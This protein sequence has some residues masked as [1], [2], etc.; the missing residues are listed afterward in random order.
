MEISFYDAP[1]KINSKYISYVYS[2]YRGT[3]LD[4]VF[5]KV[6]TMH[7]LIKKPLYNKINNKKIKLI[8]S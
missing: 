5:L 6:P 2:C 4:E 8:L 3:K 7:V 1:H